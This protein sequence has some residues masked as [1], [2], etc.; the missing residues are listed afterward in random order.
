MTASQEK[1]AA[2][3]DLEKFM[4]KIQ[5]K[6]FGITKE[7]FAKTVSALEKEMAKIKDSMATIE[8]KTKDVTDLMDEKVRS[9]NF[10]E[11]ITSDY[12][13]KKVSESVYQDTVTK[14]KKRHREI[15][16]ALKR[17]NTEKLYNEMNKITKIV[18]DHV[19]IVKDVVLQD[20]FKKLKKEVAMFDKKIDRDGVERNLFVLNEAKTGIFDRLAVLEKDFAAS[21]LKIKEITQIVA[22]LGQLEKDKKEFEKLI[23]GN[24]GEI[25]SIKGILSG[26][27][28]K[29]EG[30]FRQRLIRVEGGVDSQQHELTQKLKLAKD[31]IDLM[32]RDKLKMVNLFE[33]EIRALKDGKSMMFDKLNSNERV[34]EEMKLML[35]GLKGEL[36]VLGPKLSS[37]ENN[38]RGGILPDMVGVKSKISD[39]EMLQ[40]DLNA[41]KLK[42]N[43]IFSFDFAEKFEKITNQINDVKLD[44]YGT[45][46]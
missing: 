25:D 8:Y 24:I 4:A 15:E 16:D 37:I 39:F 22:G 30:D 32:I 44:I 21:D 27:E 42:V 11:K 23:S 14:A 1:F 31:E 10:I 7:G 36:R 13:K 46:K 17:I 28:N 2:K 26:L 33:E 41:L 40:S 12:K 35:S 29:M 19:I 43:E 20:E 38:I 5:K 18:N 6:Q 3:V 34:L 45:G 9:N